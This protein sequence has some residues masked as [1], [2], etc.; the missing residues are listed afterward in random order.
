MDDSGNVVFADLFVGCFGT[1]LD[2]DE[3]EDIWDKGGGTFRVGLEFV[4]DID[5]VG[6]VGFDTVAFALA[7]DD[8]FGHLV[9]IV[10]VLDV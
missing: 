7:F 2:A 9:T 8:Q 4:G 3:F 6:E 5:E 10:W 1:E